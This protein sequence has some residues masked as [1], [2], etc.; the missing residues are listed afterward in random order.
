[1]LWKKSFPVLLAQLCMRSCRPLGSPCLYSARPGGPTCKA[2]EA[3]KGWEQPTCSPCPFQ[4]AQA[5]FL[6]LTDATLQL[7]L[8]CIVMHESERKP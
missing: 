2:Q 3:Q 5:T 4:P 1:M 6:K 8:L 7:G